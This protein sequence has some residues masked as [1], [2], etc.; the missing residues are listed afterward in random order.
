MD[1]A[2]AEPFNPFTMMSGGHLRV[3]ARALS[4]AAGRFCFAAVPA[5]AGYVITAHPAALAPGSADNVEVSVGATT[6]VTLT[7]VP[8]ARITGSVRGEDGAAVADARVTAFRTKGGL[9]NMMT[10]GQR[11]FMANAQTDA[12]GRFTIDRLHAGDYRVMVVP[13]THE[14]P[15]SQKVTLA[16]GEVK[17]LSFLAK[18]GL[19]VSGVVREAG[20]DGQPLKGAKVSATQAQGM[21]GWPG[22]DQAMRGEDRGV[23]TDEAGRFQCA[24]LPAGELRLSVKLKGFLAHERKVHAG[25]QDL[26]VE[27]ERA[28]SIKGIVISTVDSEP[29]KQFQMALR[30]QG[31]GGFNFANMADMFERPRRFETKDGVFVVEDLDPASY[32]LT[33]TA[34]GFARQVKENVAVVKARQTKGQVI[35]LQPEGWIR[36]QVIAEDTGKPLAGARVLRKAKDT[37]FGGMFAMLTESSNVVTDAD[38]KFRVGGF[39]TEKVTLEA[40]ADGYARKTSDE[41][42]VT[43]GRGVD[44]VRIVLDRGCGVRGVVL[45]ADEKPQVRASVIAQKPAGMQM[46]MTSSDVQGRFEILGLVP[47]DYQ[48]ISLGS[49]F[50]VDP[51]N[52]MES[53]TQ[54]MQMV[55]VHLEA[56]TVKEVVIRAR[57]AGGR[58]IFGRVTAGGEPVTGAVISLIPRAQSTEGNAAF[59]FRS[60]QSGADGQYEIKDVSAGE[61]TLH[62]QST[63]VVGSFSSETV[64]HAF[65]MPAD[66]DLHYDVQ[67]SNSMLEGVVVARSDGHPLAGV[68]VVLDRDDTE[69]LMSRRRGETSTDNDGVFRFKNAQP[70]R[71][72]VAAG[73]AGLFTPAATGSFG[74]RR[75]RGLELREGENLRGLRLVLEPGAVLDGKVLAADNTPVSSAAVFLRDDTG[76]VINPLSEV[77]SDETGA[78]Q[79]NGVAPGLYTLHVRARAF[80]FATQPNV[81]ITAGA[82]NSVTVRLEKGVDVYVRLTGASGEAVRGAFVELLNT[83]GETLSAYIGIEDL[84]NMLFEGGKEGRYH[85]GMFAPG[86]YR[87]RALVPGKGK[88]EKPITLAGSEQTIDIDVEKELEKAGN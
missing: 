1:V 8:G 33:V 87:A 27:L 81:R 37:P 11:S 51:G 15:E 6:R 23:A 58:R 25:D 80:A 60:T 16:E 5:A 82:T 10:E 38:G 66:Q 31:G 14:P 48:V 22:A 67:L 9:F 24:G 42:E 88:I 12:D 84:A 21:F 50:G 47:G 68:R 3:P 34:T 18:A 75:L 49:D 29:V 43:A 54:G 63:Q 61:W 64:P 59:G 62:V 20:G 69:E 85:V 40:V 7:L 13:R 65:T 77:A 19:T 41:I 39:G 74:M 72:S 76:V 36:G 46:G 53:V 30:K 70:G 56:G 17:E 71:Y 4:D 57:Q 28:G 79:M 2:L 44:D 32:T 52:F 86:A 78:F 35:F 83:D 73:G 45:G 55:S 26:Q